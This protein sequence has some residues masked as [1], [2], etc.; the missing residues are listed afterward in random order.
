[1]AIT[2]GIV[3]IVPRQTAGIGQGFYL[4]AI[5]I[6]FTVGLESLGRKFLP[7]LIDDLLANMSREFSHIHPVYND[8]SQWGSPLAEDRCD[9]LGRFDAGFVCPSP[10]SV[11]LEN[12]GTCIFSSQRGIVR[13]EALPMAE[14]H[15]QLGQYM[16]AHTWRQRF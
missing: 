2:S 9:T 11:R 1:M 10:A 4:K 5:G 14:A 15:A 13:D 6:R 16:R 8:F 12:S 3:K 7:Q